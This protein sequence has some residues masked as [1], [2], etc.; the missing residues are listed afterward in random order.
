MYSFLTA[1][2]VFFIYG[3]QAIIIYVIA[4][5]AFDI[6]HWTL[7]QFSNSKAAILQQIGGLHDYHHKFFGENLEFNFQ[8]SKQNILYHLLPEALSQISITLLFLFWFPVAPVLIILGLFVIRFIVCSISEGKDSNHK[9]L[10]SIKNPHLSTFVGVDYHSLHHKVP[11]KF[12]SSFFPIFDWIMGTAIDLKGKRIVLTGASGALGGPLKV[13]LEKEGAIVTPLKFGMDW[14]YQ[15]YSKL[16]TLFK[17]QDILILSHGS[18]FENAQEANS[19]SFVTMIELFRSLNKTNEFPLEVWAVG[20]EIEL[21]PAFGNKKL[22]VYLNSKRS[23]AKH[24]W[25]Y[26]WDKS[27]IYRHIC[28]SSFKSQMGPGLISG[29]TAA[30]IMLFFIKRG[31]TYVPVTYTGFAFLNYFKFYFH[32]LAKFKKY[33]FSYGKVGVI[34]FVATHITKTLIAIPLYY[35]AAKQKDKTLLTIALVVHQGPWDFLAGYLAIQIKILFTGKK[36]TTPP[37]KTQPDDSKRALN[38]FY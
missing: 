5:I 22:Q 9:T 27:F 25:N 24:A 21:H 11:N 17:N 38:S 30:K 6:I 15:D 13:L 14:N 10:S 7:H 26:Y 3:L 33:I 34:A 16:E 37:Q 31:F 4:T 8:Y 2:E 19:D 18:K 28:P 12:F 1:I 23:F 36:K 29:T 32:R 20:S 35:F